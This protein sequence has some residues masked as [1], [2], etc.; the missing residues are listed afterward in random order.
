MVYDI[1]EKAFPAKVEEGDFRNGQQPPLE[2]NNVK[3]IITLGQLF[4]SASG[5]SLFAHTDTDFK[6]IQMTA[7]LKGE[8]INQRGRLEDATA[9]RGLPPSSIQS[10]L[11]ED[12]SIPGVHISDF[13]RDYT[14]KFFH[15]IFDTANENLGG[16]N[17]TLGENQAVVKQI[18]IVAAA[19]ANYLVK[20]LDGSAPYIQKANASRINEMLHC[21][22]EQSDCKG[23]SINDVFKMFSILY[24]SPLSSY[25]VFHSTSHTV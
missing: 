12:S 14:N 18:G 22:T 23:P 8:F 13:D 25:S 11:K 17:Y 6:D 2:L 5:G 7:K 10:F 16:Y 20:S 4:N 3:E 21:Y 9:N 15:G 24:S 1:T 19:V